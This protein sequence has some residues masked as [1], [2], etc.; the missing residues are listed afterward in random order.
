[1]CV[2][3]QTKTRILATGTVFVEHKFIHAC[4]KV[5]HIEDVVVLPEARGQGLGLRIVNALIDEA[6][7]RQCYKVILDCDEANVGFYEKAGMVRKEVQMA[8]YA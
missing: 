4:S 6:S 7:E 5:G 3:D 8:K 2:S 1:M